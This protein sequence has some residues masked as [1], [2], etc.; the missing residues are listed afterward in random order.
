[1]PLTLQILAQIVWTLTPLERVYSRLQIC[2]LHLGKN[3]SLCGVISKTSLLQ[4]F[5][6]SICRS[7]SQYHQYNAAI[8]ALSSTFPTSPTPLVCAETSPAKLSKHYPLHHMNPTMASSVYHQDLYH[9]QTAPE[10][11][12][13]RWGVYPKASNPPMVRAE[14]PAL[15]A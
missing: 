8:T 10:K 6:P 5:C 4:N 1:M 2:V 9:P 12:L 15:M 14:P 3:L 13:D 7:I 11:N